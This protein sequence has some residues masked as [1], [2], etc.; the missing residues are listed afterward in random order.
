MSTMRQHTTQ[1]DD[2]KRLIRWNIRA[3]HMIRETGAW[4]SCPARE[5]DAHGDAP[6]P[7]GEKN[8]CVQ[9]GTAVSDGR[10]EF[11]PCPAVEATHESQLVLSGPSW[12]V[13]R[14]CLASGKNSM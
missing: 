6:R 11:L 8:T 10:A 9:M 3:R 2:S 5:I 4:H 1:A 7:L 12:H 14:G 13:G